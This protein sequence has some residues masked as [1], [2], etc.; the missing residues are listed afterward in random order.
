MS[1]RHESP[2]HQ[3][4]PCV[5]CSGFSRLGSSSDTTVMQNINQELVGMSTTD[6]IVI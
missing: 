1:G 4:A 6:Y 5:D 3:F 2:R